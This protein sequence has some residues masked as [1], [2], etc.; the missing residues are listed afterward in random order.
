[1]GTNLVSE[2]D[3]AISSGAAAK[4]WPD[5]IVTPSCEFALGKGKVQKDRQGAIATV[6]AGSSQ[7]TPL[8]PTVS[9]TNLTKMIAHRLASRRAGVGTT[10]FVVAKAD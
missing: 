4:P 5:P 3:R 7:G 2:D 8:S 10:M 9:G 1:M 6:M